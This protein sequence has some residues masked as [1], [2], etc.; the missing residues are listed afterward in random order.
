MFLYFLPICVSSDG[1]GKDLHNCHPDHGAVAE[2]EDEQEDHRVE[3]GQPVHVVGAGGADLL[4][5]HVCVELARHLPAPGL[6]LPHLVAEPH[7]GEG[8]GAAQGGD[9][10]HDTPWAL[11]GDEHGEGVGG[12]ERQP[13]EDVGR[14]VVVV[15]HLGEDL[16]RED[17]DDV[18][19]KTMG[20]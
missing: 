13:A 12:K 17:H 11:A 8:E 5:G 2:V 18:D 6:P 20:F 3:D 10:E 15:S 1:R 16:R 19:S 9:Q 7:D 14:E 4:A